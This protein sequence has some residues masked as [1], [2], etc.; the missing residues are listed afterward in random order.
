MT[1]YGQ[2]VKFKGSLEFEDTSLTKRGSG[3][4]NNSIVANLS[5]IKMSVP[6]FIF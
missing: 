1:A 4:R 6:D 3:I 2:P 5:E